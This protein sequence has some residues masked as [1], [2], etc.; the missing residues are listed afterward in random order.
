MLKSVTQQAER[1]K[2][3]GC[4]Q[5]FDWVPAIKKSGRLLV[6]AGGCADDGAFRVVR[7]SKNRRWCWR[8]VPGSW[9]RIFGKETRILTAVPGL[10]AKSLRFEWRRLAGKQASANAQQLK[11]AGR[12]GSPGAD[13]DG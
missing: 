9:D 8:N 13:I 6:V 5:E 10:Q 11:Q 3:K 4:D 1:L 7:R 12:R 2:R